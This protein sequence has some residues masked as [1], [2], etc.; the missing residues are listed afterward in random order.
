VAARIGRSRSTLFCTGI[1]S[2]VPWEALG[3]CP[4][5]GQL[6]LFWL[7]FERPPRARAGRDRDGLSDAEERTAVRPASIRIPDGDGLLDGWRSN[8]SWT[9]A[10]GAPSAYGADPCGRMCSSDRLDGGPKRETRPAGARVAYRPPP[11]WCGSFSAGAAASGP[12]GPRSRIESFLLP[13][14]GSRRSTPT[15]L[16]SSRRQK[17]IRIRST[18]PALRRGKPEPVVTLRYLLRRLLLRTPVEHLLLRSP[19]RAEVA[20]ARTWRPRRAGL[21]LPL[22]RQLR[23]RACRRDGLCD[24]GS[25]QPCLP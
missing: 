22:H 17:V 15:R 25:S 23:G 2:R 10:R 21:E 5:P 1:G 14:P 3:R 11:T 7:A 18:P 19:G 16:R 9:G 24:A 6:P 4:L 13:R 12:R 8:G 20:S